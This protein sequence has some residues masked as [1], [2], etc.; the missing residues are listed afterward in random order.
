MTDR[1][2][3]PG[4]FL[5]EHFQRRMQLRKKKEQQQP[6][7]QPSPQ[8]RDQSRQLR[9]KILQLLK[10]PHQPHLLH[11]ALR[12]AREQGI[13]SRNVCDSRGIPFI[14]VA[15]QHS[16][17]NTQNL[18][19]LV[20]FGASVHAVD[21]FDGNT[22]LH[23]AV[24]LRFAKVVEYLLSCG[25]DP[26]AVD[27]RGRTPLMI[28][29]FK[30]YD[31]LHWVLQE[32]GGADVEQQCHGGSTSL[33][34]SSHGVHPGTMEDPFLDNDGVQEKKVGVDPLTTRMHMRY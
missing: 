9:K 23:I 18:K 1:H 17:G 2:L 20:S 5:H 13:S 6:L 3:Q 11:Q 21:R 31:H 8:P 7:Q 15:T 10:I 28:S 14:C 30:Q 12:K 34:W 16:Q 29:S 27:A 22:P 33:A 32:Q 4:K 19:L 24:T 25:A 26:N